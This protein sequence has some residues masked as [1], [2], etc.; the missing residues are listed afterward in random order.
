[1]D[2]RWK[3]KEDSLGSPV[4]IIIIIITITTTTKQLMLTIDYLA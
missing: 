1:M 3:R 2:S 4:I